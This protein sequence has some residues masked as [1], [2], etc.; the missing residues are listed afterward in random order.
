MI[1]QKARAILRDAA[2]IAGLIA[3]LYVI[4]QMTKKNE[5]CSCEG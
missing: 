5:E 2:L 4:R 3:S 1:P